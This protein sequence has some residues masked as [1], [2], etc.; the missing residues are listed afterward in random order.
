LD[1]KEYLAQLQQREIK[2]NKVPEE[3]LDFKETLVHLVEL[4]Q[5]VRG[6]NQD[7]KVFLVLMEPQE[8]KVILELQ[9]KLETEEKLDRKVKEVQEGRLV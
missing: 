6:E 3:S 2:E 9:E 4:D 8:L 5:L 1:Q 7:H